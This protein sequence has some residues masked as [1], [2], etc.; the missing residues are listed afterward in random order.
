[1]KNGN[2]V[3]KQDLPRAMITSAEGRITPE[4]QRTLKFQ[5]NQLEAELIQ[6]ALL[7][8][9]GDRMAAAARLGIG[10]SSLYAK[11]EQYGLGRNA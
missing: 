10:K 1:M 8:T 11:V 7:E 2:L 4:N 5:L 6:Q 9:K 3:Q